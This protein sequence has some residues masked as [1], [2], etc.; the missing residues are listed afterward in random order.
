MPR[1]SIQ[2]RL[3]VTVIFSQ[4]LLAAGLLVAGI[5]YTHRRLLSTLLWWSP[6]SHA[7]STAGIPSCARI[8]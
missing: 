6:S 7:T 1:R 2:N 5:Y 4:A 3:I 8:A